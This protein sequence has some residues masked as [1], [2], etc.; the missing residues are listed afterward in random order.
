MRQETTQVFQLGTHRIKF[1]Q[2]LPQFQVHLHEC[3]NDVYNLAWFFQVKRGSCHAFWHIL[4]KRNQSLE[5]A[6]H[7][8]LDS[9]G[10][11][12]LFLDVRL[13]GDMRSKVRILLGKFA[14]CHTLQALHDNLNGAVGHAYHAGDTRNGTNFEDVIWPGLFHLSGLL[15]DQNDQAITTHDLVNQA[16]RSFLAH[17]ERLDSKRIDDCILE[18]QNRQYI[19]YAKLIIIVLLTAA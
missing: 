8:A 15:G 14:D 1:K 16:N 9:L 7:V 5:V 6:N 3:G 11:I 18:R 4:H 13:Q 12:V 17:A 10:C 2:L 19:W